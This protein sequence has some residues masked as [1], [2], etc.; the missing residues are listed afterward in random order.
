MKKYAL[1][2]RSFM[3]PVVA[4]LAIW[5]L[6]KNLAV[7]MAVFAA[8]LVPAII[9][10]YIPYAQDNPRHFWFKR[11]IY[12]WGWTPVTWQGWLVTLG[13]VIAIAGF[14]LTLDENSPPNEIMFTFILPAVLL[15]IALI[16]VAYRKGERPR[17]QWGINQE[18]N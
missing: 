18:E 15:T 10:L 13:Y 17:W 4:G 11:K 5:I 14:A 2:P 3:L 1:Q 6:S 12:G 8:F 7:G 16:R 9:N